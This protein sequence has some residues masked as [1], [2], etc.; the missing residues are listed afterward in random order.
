MNNTQ[1]IRF[2][3]LQQWLQ[4]FVTDQNYSLTPASSDASFR[5]YFRLEQL[6][7]SYI[8][9]DSPPEH[10]DNHAF[11]KVA[12][13]LEQ[14]GLNVPHIYQQDLQRG[15]LILSDLGSVP[16]LS[17]LSATTADELY[18]NAINSLITLQKIPCENQPLPK[19][20]SALLQREMQLFGEWFLQKHLQLTPPDWLT[21][22]YDLLIDNA[23]SQP[24]VLVHRDFHSRNLMYLPGQAPGVIDF[25]DAVIG[26]ISYDLVSL[27]RDVYIQWSPSQQKQWVEYY[28]E[29]AQQHGLL[30]AEQAEH[31]PRWF[32]LMGLQ[33]HLKIL[34]I[35]CRLNYRDNKPNYMNNLALTL[36]YVYQVCEQYP[37]LQNLYQYLIEQPKIVAIK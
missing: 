7:G 13:L 30:S 1:D 26:A 9:M 4:S 17:M 24:Q 19:Y 18:K 33:R 29:Q 12:R 22:T 20:D 34:G 27:L 2:Q 8:I 21:A 16:Y 14:Y 36:N 5:R 15:F 11:I 23:L 31:F 3:Q 32:D 6:G 25:Q 28:I 10:E 37:E 35:F